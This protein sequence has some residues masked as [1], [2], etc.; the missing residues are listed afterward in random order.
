MRRL[1]EVSKLEATRRLVVVIDETM[2]TV[3]ECAERRDGKVFELWTME[4]ISATDGPKAI[5]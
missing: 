2:D 4:R 5:S 1:R 3:E